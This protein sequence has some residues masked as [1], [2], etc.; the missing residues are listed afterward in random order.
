[1]TRA[2]YYAEHQKLV[3]KLQRMSYIVNVKQPAVPVASRVR[4]PWYR[5]CVE[6]EVPYVILYKGWR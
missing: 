3:D 6:P 1:V 5:I 2:T 4:I